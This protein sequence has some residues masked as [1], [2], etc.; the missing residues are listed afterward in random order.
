MRFMKY[1]LLTALALSAVAPAY[2]AQDEAR[3]CMALNIYFEARDQTAT[4]AVAVGFVVLNRIASKR[5]PNT[6]CKVVWQYKQFSW[7]L[8]GKS[9]RPRE[10]QAWKT[11]QMLADLVMSGDYSDPTGGAL[12]YHAD[13]A[14]PYWMNVKMKVTVTLGAH[15]FYR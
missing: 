11:A 6:I 13:Y 10:K 9:D 2:A 8:D 4:A 3:R 14:K 12:F 15:I 7:T 5:F 1:T